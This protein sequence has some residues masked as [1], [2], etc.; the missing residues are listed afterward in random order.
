MDQM[1]HDQ[2]LGESL[3]PSHDVSPATDTKRSKRSAV[4]VIAAAVLLLVVVAASVA[5]YVFVLDVPSATAE[6]ST[7]VPAAQAPVATQA[8][9]TAQEPPPVPLSRVFTFRDIFDPLIESAEA[10][11][12][13]AP[14]TPA[15][16]GVTVEESITLE[17]VASIDGVLVARLRFRGVLHELR[18]GQ[19]IP[20]EP[21][22]V[23]SVTENRVE[24]LWGDEQV[25]LGIGDV[26]TPPVK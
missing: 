25:S 2:R 11:D 24:L 16:P 9:T 23:L 18:A 5:A 21:L 3:S 15:T 14:T 13:P 12:A 22:Q 20:G 26:Y 1:K 17:S 7:P 4:M 19:Q 8:A 6:F 10:A